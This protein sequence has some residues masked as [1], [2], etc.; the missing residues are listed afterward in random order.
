M[1]FSSGY[2][3]LDHLAAVGVATDAYSRV[4]DAVACAAWRRFGAAFLATY[5]D[6]DPPWA[7]EQFGAPDAHS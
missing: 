2:D 5:A 3:Y 1:L 7:L 6:N 4:T